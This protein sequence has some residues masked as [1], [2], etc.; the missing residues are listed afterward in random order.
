MRAGG[1]GPGRRSDGRP[2]GSSLSHTGRDDELTG[3]FNVMMRPNADARAALAA[4]YQRPAPRAASA[5]RRCT[6]MTGCGDS[7]RGSGGWDGDR[8]GLFLLEK[9]SQL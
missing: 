6:T 7:A 3:K 9:K 1:P 8:L 4:T 2:P 5:T